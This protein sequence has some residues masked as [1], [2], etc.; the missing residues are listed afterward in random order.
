MMSATQIDLLGV[1]ASSSNRSIALCSALDM[2]SYN[3]QQL[4]RK[5]PFLKSA[6]C[7]V[8]VPVAKWIENR[9]NPLV[10]LFGRVAHPLTVVA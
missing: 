1:I 10:L 7:P 8:A 6:I 9:T 5:E 3:H 2:V 4:S